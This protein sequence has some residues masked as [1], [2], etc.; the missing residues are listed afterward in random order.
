M[1]RGKIERAAVRAVEEFIDSFAKMEPNIFAGDKERIWDGEIN[2]FENEEIKNENFFA[3][4]PIQVKGT[5]NTTDKSYRIGREHLIGYKK[6]RGTLFFWVQEDENLKPIKILYNLLSS[7]ALDTLLEQVTKTIKIDLK[8]MPENPDDF[9]KE[10]FEFARIRNGEDLDNPGTKEIESLLMKFVKIEEYVDKIEN[11]KKRNNLKFL[12]DELKKLK[13]DNTVGWRDKFVF[14]SQNALDIAIDNI[15]DNDDGFTNLQFELGTYLHN[16]K[17][18]HLVEDYYV[19]VLKTC[20]E[21]AKEYPFSFNKGNVATTLNNLGVLHDDL[22]RH[23][24]AEEEYKEA[25]EIFRELAK[26]NPNAYMGKVAD[27]VENLGILHNNLNCHKEAEEEYKEALKIRRE[28]AKDNPNAY[29]G[30]VADTVENLGVLH[31][32]LNRHKE[33]EEEYKEA[34][35][36]RRELAKD[37][38]NAYMGKVAKSLNGLAYLYAK[39]HN[40]SK[41]IDTIDEAIAIMPNYAEYYD[42]KGEILLM[43]G[44]E[45]DA[46]TMWRKVMELDPDFMSKHNGETELHSQLKEKG[47]IRE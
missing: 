29:M 25:L 31:D 18:Y 27:T 44:D 2:V 47:L 13:N 7:D 46:L 14:Y 12:L 45:Q 39:Q 28:L 15:K 23:K 20:R 9:E 41:A 10:I 1:D 42:S 36:I 30:K 17:Q 32:D 35:K 37:N 5:T 43:K 19:K 6:E 24:E 26:D 21:R 16:Q 34:L 38:P 40:F 8:E 22:N 33:A 11:S 3:K 4:I